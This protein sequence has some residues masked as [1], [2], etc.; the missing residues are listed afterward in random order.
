M[1]E[2]IFYVSNSN[3]AYE[4]GIE[5]LI[6]FFT[7]LQNGALALCNSCLLLLDFP[8]ELFNPS[9]KN[10]VLFWVVGF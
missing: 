5:S 7:G 1:I 8:W 4:R 6:V 2:I 3:K 9:L 10:T